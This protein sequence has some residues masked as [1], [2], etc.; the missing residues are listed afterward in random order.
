[1]HK[2]FA[3][4][5]REYLQSVKTKMFWIGTLAF[6]LFIVMIFGLTGLAD[7]VKKADHLAAYNSIAIEATQKLMLRN[8]G[9][10]KKTETCGDV[11]C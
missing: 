4:V 9:I 5:R 11:L 6:P 10:F 3:V 2:I 1:M 8:I 7:L